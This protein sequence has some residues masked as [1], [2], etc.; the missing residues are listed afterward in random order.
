MQRGHQPELLDDLGRQ[1]DG[2]NEAL[3]HLHEVL[4]TQLELRSQLA[5][6]ADSRPQE[7]A[8]GHLLG[9]L[10]HQ[11]NNMVVTSAG[12]HTRTCLQSPRWHAIGRA[13]SDNDSQRTFF[14]TGDAGLHSYL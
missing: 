11:S 14:D 4:L 2:V 8:T 7:R 9:H 10:A 12:N 3:L 13:Y 6:V 1:H 5:D